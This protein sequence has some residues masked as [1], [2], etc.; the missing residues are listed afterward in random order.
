VYDSLTALAAD[1]TAKPYLAQSLTPNADYTQWTIT[2][3]PNVQFSDGEPF[4][5]DAMVAD[6]NALLKSLLTGPVL[7]DIQGVS[8]VNDTSVLVTMKPKSASCP[9]CGP[10]ADFPGSMDSQLGFMVA[11]KAI[12]DP[13]RAHA[14]IGTGPF[15][16]QSWVPGDHFTAVKN[17]HYWRKDAAGNQLP[18]LDSVTFKPIPDPQSRKN[19]LLS[20]TIDML[21]T[22]DTQTIVDLRANHSVQ[23]TELT[24][25]RAEEDFVVLNTTS[26]PLDDLRIRQ[27]LAMGFDQNRY[28]QIVNNGILKGANGPFSDGSGFTNAPNYPKYDP[29]GAKQLV[30][31][32]EA[33]HHVS[34]V[35]LSLGTTNT[36]KNLA[37]NQL[38]ADMWSQVGLT[39]N[40]V[41]VE[42]SK[43]IVNLVTGNFQAYAVSQYS[44]PDPDFDFIWWGS[45]FANPPLSTNFS[46]NKDPLLDQSMVDARATNDPARRKQDY[47]NVSLQL[48]KDLPNIWEDQVLW[49]YAAKPSVQGVATVTLPDGSA[50]RPVWGGVIAPVELWVKH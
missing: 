36:G 32:Y 41:Q 25:G 44:E 8:K 40:V 5:A 49:A 22:S 29:A 24:A 14:P 17:Q 43:L 47:E 4:N 34:K 18:Y 16:F 35:S 27:A 3:R 10:W 21:H 15:I 19:S 50:A 42:Q 45:N 37:D 9:N 39:V 11:P 30:Q 26:A 7:F 33:D 6:F 12:S 46:R 13:N 31:Q 2:A 1:G 23:L 28:N 38:V 48:N 20:G